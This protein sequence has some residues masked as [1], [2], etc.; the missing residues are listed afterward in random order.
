MYRREAVELERLGGRADDAGGERDGDTRLSAEHVEGVGEDAAV[1]IGV[2][3]DVASGLKTLVR[4]EPSWKVM[5]VWRSSRSND[6]VVV[7]AVVVHEADRSCCWRH[8]AVVVVTVSKMA[9]RA[10]AV[11]AEVLSSSASCR[12]APS[13]LQ[14]VVFGLGSIRFVRLPRLS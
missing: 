14:T 6:Q 4:V 12:L 10:V 2:A 9:L 8:S 7:P 1:L 11:G 13:K 3:D 5:T